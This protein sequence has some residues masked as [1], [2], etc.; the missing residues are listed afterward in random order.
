MR[1]RKTSPTRSFGGSLCE[2][3]TLARRLSEGRNS[4]PAS[5]DRSDFDLLD[6]AL[7]RGQAF[8]G[9]SSAALSS[10]LLFSGDPRRPPSAPGFSTR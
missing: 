3:P 8:H 9:R 2:T 6:P 4:S 5:D 7:R 1:R 10:L